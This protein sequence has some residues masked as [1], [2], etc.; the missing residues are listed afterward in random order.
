MTDNYNAEWKGQ[1][2]FNQ[3]QVVLE[4]TGFYHVDFHGCW[5]KV[6]VVATTGF[7]GGPRTDKQI[8]D[9]F[10]MIGEYPEKHYFPIKFSP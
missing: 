8:G 7:L 9:E 1:Q 2:I 4:E 5:H 10:Y 6:K 3:P